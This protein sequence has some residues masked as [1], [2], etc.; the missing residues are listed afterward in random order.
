VALDQL[1]RDFKDGFFP[2]KIESV[3][4]TERVVRMLVKTLEPQAVDA[5]LFDVPA[6]YTEMKMP[7]GRP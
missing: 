1:M 6:D 7:V 4:S 3:T 2:L 5:K